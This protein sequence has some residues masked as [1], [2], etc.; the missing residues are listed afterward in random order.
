MGV[1]VVLNPFEVAAFRPWQWEN[2][3]QEAPNQDELSEIRTHIEQF[4]AA[5]ESHD[6]DNIRPFYR[7]TVEN[8]FGNENR[9]LVPDIRAAY[10]I[11]WK[12]YVGERHEIDWESLEVSQEEESQITRVRFSLRYYFKTE[13]AD[14]KNLLL[15]TE[16]RLDAEQKI[17]YIDKF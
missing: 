10:L 3:G 16:I 17:F 15:G 14:W 12:K 4:Y 6:F 8:Y 13:E 11:Y 1:V 7:E 9:R 5:V 2:W